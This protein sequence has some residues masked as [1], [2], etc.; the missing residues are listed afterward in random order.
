MSA[1]SQPKSGTTAIEW[2]AAA[3]MRRACE[4][5]PS[6][7]AGGGAGGSAAS[8][9]GAANEPNVTCALDADAAA[10][11]RT[12]RATFSVG[13]HVAVALAFEGSNK[14]DGMV[15]RTDRD[16]R[17]ASNSEFHKG[18]FGQIAQE[19]IAANQSAWSAP[20]LAKVEQ[21]LV[22]VL[23]TGEALPP[24]GAAS[25]DALVLVHS[26]RDPIAITSSMLAYK[27]DVFQLGPQGQVKRCAHYAASVALRHYLATVLLPQAGYEVVTLEFGAARRTP[28]AHARRLAWAMGIEALPDDQLRQAMEEVSPER[29][30]K[31]QAAIGAGVSPSEAVSAAGAASAVGIGGGPNNH[32]VGNASVTGYRQQLDKQ[33]LSECYAVAKHH[34]PP[35][36]IERYYGSLEE[37]G[38]EGGAC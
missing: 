5:V 17:L 34:L 6:S 21:A 19:C 31:V 14:H 28:L 11:Q 26:Q 13:G 37:G 7:L 3:L 36:L 25:G 24:R 10:G 18:V 33:V 30:R 16:G 29:M 35:E 20:C 22:D 1:D 9:S 38:G 15:L 32:K 23:A 2:L 8:G 27:Q 4:C 12:L